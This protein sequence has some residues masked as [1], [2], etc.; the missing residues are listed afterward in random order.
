MNVFLSR[1]KPLINFCFVTSGSVDFNFANLY[2]K[3]EFISNSFTENSRPKAW[4]SLLRSWSCQFVN[5]VFWVV[6]VAVGAIV[7]VVGNVDWCNLGIANSF[8]S[9]S[10]K[11]PNS[12]SILKSIKNV[13]SNYFVINF[14]KLFLIYFFKLFFI[15]FLNY[16]LFTFLNYFFLNYFLF[17]FLNYFLFYFFK[18]FFIDFFKFF[19]IYFFKGVSCSLNFFDFLDLFFHFWNLWGLP[20]NS[21]C[22]VIGVS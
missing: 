1:M 21:P 17:T 9:R 7:V 4:C 12:L 20:K 16:F 2:F 18:L 22:H 3:N 19:V 6:V 13:F 8:I 5:A 11:G 14:F 10:R 15:Y